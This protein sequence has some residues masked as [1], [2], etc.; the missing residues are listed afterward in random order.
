M[1]D[2]Y[3]HGK[4]NAAVVNSAEDYETEEYD[5][6][7]A[8]V[9]ASYQGPPGFAPSVGEA[10]PSDVF[11]PI[12]RAT[13]AFLNDASVPFLSW[14]TDSGATHHMTPVKSYL[15]N[16]RPDV[17]PCFVQIA[18][19]KLI[20]RAGVGSIRVITEVNGITYKKEIGNVWYLPEFGRSL[21][22][23]QQL[24]RQGCWVIAGYNGNPTEF[25]FEGKTCWLECPLQNGLNAP[26]WEL[27]HN[28]DDP[29]CNPPVL[30][31]PP[32]VSNV[33][34]DHVAKALF[35]TA[36]KATDPE[37]PHLWHQRLGH[38]NFENLNR[39]VRHNF[40]KGITIPSTTFHQASK[41]PCQVCI[42]AKHNRAPFQKNL[43]KPTEPMVMLG[44]DTCG[45]YP[46]ESLG[47][48]KYV[49]TL[50]DYCTTFTE[51]SVCKTKK[52]LP[53]ELKRMILAWETRTGKKVKYIFSDRGGEFIE[54]SL[55]HWFHEK[56]IIHH[57]S[58]P[59][60]PQQN[61]LA[62][63]VNQT[64][65]NLVRAMLIQYNLYTPLWSF[66]M[67]YATKIK[68]TFYVKRVGMT[69]HEAFLGTVP[70]VSNF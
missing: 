59:R 19:D 18:D 15:F 27:V 43:P 66:A 58:V 65:N 57:F 38:Q 52:E 31:K 21:L 17:N 50:V 45:P 53:D 46:V 60:T 44:S 61:G 40:V 23:V 29:K 25:V 63:R 1:G 33:V 10:P 26:K 32:P 30:P 8:G 68:N 4:A 70:D 34:P 35:A 16:Y 14:I 39:L 12:G 62:E 37:T 24:K 41:C 55:K 48:G 20:R 6:G 51:T 11:A 7:Y 2:K 3:S 13:N 28:R 49:L 5:L 9:A 22:S 56:G 36:N 64:L 67:A 54:T 69:P 42:M 47:G